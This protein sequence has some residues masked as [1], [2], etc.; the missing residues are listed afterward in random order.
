MGV[1]LPDCPLAKGARL[2]SA[3]GMELRR[4][5][6]GLLDCQTFNGSTGLVRGLS[7]ALAR[8]GRFSIGMKRLRR[9][10]LPMGMGA[11]ISPAGGCAGILFTVY[12]RMLKSSE[13]G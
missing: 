4:K 12:G 8:S 1:R 6:C 9:C 5:R 11:I 3:R 2:L 13:D 7:V 10:V